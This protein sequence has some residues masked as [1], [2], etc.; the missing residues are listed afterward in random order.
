[1]QGFALEAS[2]SNESFRGQ[3]CRG[4]EGQQQSKEHVHTYTHMLKKAYMS[5]YT[6]TFAC[7]RTHM[8]TCLLVHTH[9][10]VLMFTCPTPNKMK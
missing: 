2:V 1:M 3:G 9:T 10:C 5:T 6:C 8:H 7:T 4:K